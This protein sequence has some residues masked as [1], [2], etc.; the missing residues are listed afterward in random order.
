MPKQ[1]NL[2]QSFELGDIERLKLPGSFSSATYNDADHILAM[3]WQYKQDI[4]SITFD[5][6]E[7]NVTVANGTDEQHEM[8]KARLAQHGQADAKAQ[9]QQSIRHRARSLEGKRWQDLTTADFRNILLVL[10]W[11]H[12]S[13]DNEGRVKPLNEWTRRGD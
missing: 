1:F 10:M 3:K 8:L 9:N 7:Q 4:T 11:D 6:G 5:F 2:P 12:K 13:I